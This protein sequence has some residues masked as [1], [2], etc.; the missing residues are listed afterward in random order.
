MTCAELHHAYRLFPCHALIP[1]LSLPDSRQ[2]IVDGFQIG[3]DMGMYAS[4]RYVQTAHVARDM[5]GTSARVILRKFRHSREGLT[6]RKR[7][8]AVKVNTHASVRSIGAAAVSSV[9]GRVPLLAASCTYHSRLYL[10]PIRSRR[11]IR[12]CMSPHGAQS[13][14]RIRS[15]FR[16]WIF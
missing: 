11:R 9:A 4:H 14:G 10:I 2:Q 7:K 3:F 5:M 12:G 16:R 8:S 1:T 15:L 13:H 6:S